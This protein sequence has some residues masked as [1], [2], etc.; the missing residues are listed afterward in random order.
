MLII[1]PVGVLKF[2]TTHLGRQFMSCPRF[3][4]EGVSV[5]C[6]EPTVTKI[7]CALQNF[8]YTS[9]NARFPA[10]PKGGGEKSMHYRRKNFPE[11]FRTYVSLN[12]GVSYRR[13]VKFSFV[14]KFSTWKEFHRKIHGSICIVTVHIYM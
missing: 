5:G 9:T 13:H 6:Y 1:C 2:C 8:M 10:V 12:W 3:T 7:F 14:Q 11:M 4:Q